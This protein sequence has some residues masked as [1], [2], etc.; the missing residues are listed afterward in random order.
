MYNGT[1]INEVISLIK[2]KIKFPHI[3]DKEIKNEAVAKS[4]MINDL[5]LICGEIFAHFLIY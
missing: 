4:Y 3:K 5:L 1:F 2:K